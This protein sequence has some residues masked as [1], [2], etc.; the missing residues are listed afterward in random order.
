[1]DSYQNSSPVTVAPNP[2]EGKFIFYDMEVG[3][4]IE[5]FDITGRRVTSTIATD[6]SCAVD[7]SV[8]GA[9]VYFYTITRDAEKIQQG[10]L[11][12]E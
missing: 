11:V 12:V 9:G 7:L 8:Y 6:A 1:M 3:N 4:T 5:V 2:S 10:K